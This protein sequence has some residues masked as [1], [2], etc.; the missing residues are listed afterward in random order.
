MSGGREGML[1]LGCCRDKVV[2]LQTQRSHVASIKVGAAT[3]SGAL[4]KHD[5]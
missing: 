5:L 2:I 3:L 4:G 1:A